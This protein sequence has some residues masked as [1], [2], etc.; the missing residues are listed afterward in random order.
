MSGRTVLI[1][2]A[3]RGIGSACVDALASAG[4]RIVLAA[5]SMSH[6]E[7][8]ARMIRESGGEAFAVEMDLSKTESIV[9]GFSK[10]SKEF[11]PIGILVNNAGITK[12]GLAVRM[13][14][15]DWDLVLRTNLT[16][17]FHAI[18][19]VLPGMMKERWGR[20]GNSSSVVGE[21]GRA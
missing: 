5:R 20:M 16:G 21:M 13:K 10:A 19:Q 1:T 15:A 18:Q 8:K 4:H 7:E 12:D 9:D 17:A 3:S 2:G 6:L 14:P 11:G